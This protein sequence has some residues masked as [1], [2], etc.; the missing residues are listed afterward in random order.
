MPAV[1]RRT[2]RSVRGRVG[3][4]LV[5]VDG[6]A[7]EAK[8]VHL[9]CRQMLFGDVQLRVL[10]LLG[11]DSLCRLLAVHVTGS[12]RALI[13]VA[14]YARLSSA[15]TV[16]SPQMFV[17]GVAS[18]AWPRFGT[19]LFPRTLSHAAVASRPVCGSTACSPYIHRMS[20]VSAAGIAGGSASVPPLLRTIRQLVA[21]SGSVALA[22]S[23]LAP[24]ALSLDVGLSVRRAGCPA[25]A[26][27]ARLSALAG[28][29][30]HDAGGVAEAAALVLPLGRAPLG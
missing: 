24:A 18:A 15:S 16:C 28:D 27:F 3:L 6:F 22:W 30:N 9:R 4:T 26:L 1:L 23:G 14:L 12:V 20:S 25:S 7:V 17:S 21:R 29:V 8:A 5:A 13:R 11:F 10:R 2:A 19:L